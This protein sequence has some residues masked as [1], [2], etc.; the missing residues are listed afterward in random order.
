MSEGRT[1]KEI[2]RALS[3]A[4]DTAKKYVQ[5]IIA[6]LDASDRTHATLKAARAGL[7]K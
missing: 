4:E 3:I 1:N 7:I 6:K 2:G 5:S